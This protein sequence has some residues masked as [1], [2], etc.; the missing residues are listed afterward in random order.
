M[1]E[2][3]HV[4]Q[5][6]MGLAHDTGN[7]SA[8][9]E[10]QAQA[11]QA[12]GSMGS[13][14]GFSMPTATAAAPVQGF[15]RRLVKKIKGLFSKAPASDY[16]ED[17]LKQN[18]K[19][20]MRFAKPQIADY[21]A[22][23]LQ[24]T[25]NY[26]D[27]APGA[28]G[29]RFVAMRGNNGVLKNYYAS[30]GK[31]TSGYAD[32]YAKSRFKNVSQLPS[33]IDP[34]DP[35]HTYGQ[36]EIAPIYGDPTD[37]HLLGLKKTYQQNSVN[38]VTNLLQMMGSSQETLSAINTAASQY[39]DTLGDFNAETNPGGLTGGRME[40]LHRAMNDVILRTVFNKSQ[41]AFKAYTD[42]DQKALGTKIN[43]EEFQRAKIA[44]QFSMSMVNK[45]LT[46]SASGSTEGAS[47]EELALYEA[48][49]NF[50]TDHNLDV[51]AQA[52][53]ALNNTNAKDISGPNTPVFTAPRSREEKEAN[54]ATYVERRPDHRM[55]KP[56]PGTSPFG[57]RTYISPYSIPK[58]QPLKKQQKKDDE[59]YGNLRKTRT[60]AVKNATAERENH[61]SIAWKNA[62]AAEKQAW[63][64]YAPIWNPESSTKT[65]ANTLRMADKPKAVK[66]RQALEK[67][68][69]A[70]SDTMRQERLQ[71]LQSALERSDRPDIP[72][73]FTQKQPKNLP[74][75]QA[76]RFDQS[77][78]IE[79]KSGEEINKMLYQ[80]AALD[81]KKRK[82]KK[83]LE[84]QK[85]WG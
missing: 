53:R 42:G 30:L 45:A 31:A 75:K 68:A 48:M 84:R 77:L 11:V 21:G 37:P 35:T 38:D 67:K 15:G 17:E 79:E 28:D 83:D 80:A 47:E 41:D 19:I 26:P 32:T 70:A 13:T 52:Q 82:Q 81:E 33:L 1:H 78:G 73:N 59:Y 6:G 14:A 18:A 76:S 24:D 60:A 54:P 29:G 66:R 34:H 36:G 16:K 4:V 72:I 22:K 56:L 46:M 5:Q 7:E 39:E 20:A 2:A 64:E 55:D 71:Q 69:Q 62:D 12:G 50:F 58:S 44:N 49:N 25:A 85:K 9:L 51:S 43:A 74:L 40:A 3:A 8:A 27:W 61:E 57:E 63:A 10:A 23:R 65:I